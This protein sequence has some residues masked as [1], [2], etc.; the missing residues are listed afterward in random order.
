[1]GIEELPERI[2]AHLIAKTTRTE[3][4]SA[5]N[6]I[7]VT[8]LLGC[9]KKSY[10]RRK[11]PMPI[12]LKQAFV[13]FRGQIFDDAFTPLFARNQVRVT[14]RIVGTPIVI[15]GRID[16][17][18]DDGAVADW[19]TIDGTYWIESK[20]AKEEN[21]RQVL[22]YCYCEGI[23]KGR[24]YYMSLGNLIKIDIDANQEV[25]LENLEDLEERAKTLN[26]ALVCGRTPKR[27]SDHTP[28]FWECS[29]T[30]GKDEFRCEYY[31]TCYG[32]KNGK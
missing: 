14:H 27:D 1:M 4:K 6:R 17:I 3:R 21:V 8:E 16:F 15:T 31:D 25:Q 28:D 5:N 23:D 2:K 11:E 10:L 32:E 26:N 7:G 9:Q 19:K 29:Y 20:G 30:K 12:S 13:F 22:F 24:L 18:D